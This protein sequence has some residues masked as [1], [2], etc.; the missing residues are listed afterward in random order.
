M[1]GHELTVE[2]RE[3]GEEH[4]RRQPCQRDLGRIGPP[5][6]HALAEKGLSQRHAIQA[7]DQLLALP[8]LDGMGKAD[9]VQVQVGPLNLP[10]DPGR[11]PILR[12]LC[13]QPDDPREI[14]IGRDP[15][16]LPPDRLGQRV[17]HMKTMQRHDRPP[18]RLDP[19]NLLRIPVIG[20]GKHADGIGLQQDQG[21][22]RHQPMT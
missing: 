2:Q 9:L 14:A 7:A 22:N 16:P 5:R 18:L 17:R 3:P 4:S 15:K 20:H 1:V 8:H 10:I 12:R 19:I 6:H 11:R 21:I 13:A